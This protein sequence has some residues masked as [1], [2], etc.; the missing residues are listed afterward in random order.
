MVSRT[1]PEPL[2]HQVVDEIRRRVQ[3]GQWAPGQRV[4]SER[5]FAE[6]LAVSRIT[7]RHAMRLAV[8]EGLLKQQR[9]VGT[10]VLGPGRVEQNLAEVRS[11]ERTLADRGQMASTQILAS[12]SLLADLQLAGTL[13][14]DP[15]E[16]VYNLRLLGSGDSSPVVLYDSYFSI[17][18]GRQM[19]AAAD[20]MLAAGRPFST[21]DLY[22]VESVS[23]VPT[24]LSQTIEA[25][26]APP[27]VADRLGLE[28]SS[29][30]LMVESVMVDDAGPVEFRR[31]YYRG[32]RYKFGIQRR[33]GALRR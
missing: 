16:P 2:Y 29:P 17:E 4:P 33:L 11:F 15:A 19:A 3:S 10:F 21:L 32:D 25:L 13:G 31:G 22:R 14:L 18:L 8:T 27:E 20:Q 9:G 6:D 5:Q 1:R 12:A 7:V 23:R 28:A 24:S 26:A 30:S